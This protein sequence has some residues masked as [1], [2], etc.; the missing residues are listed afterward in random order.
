L[1]S[2]EVGGRYLE[3]DQY[4]ALKAVFQNLNNDGFAQ[5]EQNKRNEEARNQNGHV[6]K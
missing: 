4:N 3:D 2:H 1:D 6:V 5:E